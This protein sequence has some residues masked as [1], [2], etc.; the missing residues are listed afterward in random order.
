MKK[1][2][3]HVAEKYIDSAIVQKEIINRLM[4]RLSFFNL[5]PRKVALILVQGLGL[6]TESLLKLHPNSEFYMIDYS[7]KSL[8]C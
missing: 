1:L 5:S 6:S 7:F 3:K 4:Q 2:K 8:E